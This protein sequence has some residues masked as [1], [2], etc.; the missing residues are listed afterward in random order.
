MTAGRIN[1]KSVYVCVVGVRGRKIRLGL[2]RSNGD[3]RMRKGV[4]GKVIDE[5]G[6]F[7]T[8]MH[9]CTTPLLTGFRRLFLLTPAEK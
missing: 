9:S 6:R 4:A 1:G 7:V 5:P 2:C 3:S 8:C